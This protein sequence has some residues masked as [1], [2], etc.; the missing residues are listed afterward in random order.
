MYVIEDPYTWQSWH[1]SEK[2]F[3]KQINN[4]DMTEFNSLSSS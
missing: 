2:F 4:N 1:I 3:I